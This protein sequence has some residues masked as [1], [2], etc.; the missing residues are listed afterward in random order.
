M[1]QITEPELEKLRKVIDVLRL[2]DRQIPA[3]VMSTFFY[4]ASHDACKPSDAG[5]VLNM[6]ASSLRRCTDWLSLWASPAFEDTSTRVK[7]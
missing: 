3:Q 1:V 6:T 7:P 5:K 4:I 2:F